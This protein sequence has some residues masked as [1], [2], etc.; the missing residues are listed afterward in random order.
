ME[1]FFL[2]SI[3][4]DVSK[5]K[6]MVAVLRPL[7]EVV[8]VPFEVN[9]TVKELTALIKD[10]KSL[11]GD[12]KVFME[13][14]G[15]YHLPIANALT[16]AGFKVHTLNAMLIKN[17][18]NNSI[19]KVKTDKADALKIANY[20]LTYWND[21]TVYSIDD[22]IRIKLKSFN[23]QYSKYIK[24]RTAM[25]NNFTSLID[26]SFPGV[27]TLFSSP[28]RKS[29]GHKK[30][31]DFSLRYWHCDCVAAMSLN[32]FISSYQAWCKVHKY[33][34]SHSKAEEIHQF[35]R[36]CCPV[37]PKDEETK[38]LIC[39]A[40][41]ELNTLT[42]ATNSI[43]VKALELAS[44]LPE[45]PVV[46]KMYGVGDITAF[47]LIAEIGNIYRFPRKTSLVS[48]AGLDTEPNDSGI[49][50]HNSNEITKKGSPYLRRTLFLVMSNI[51]MLAPS[52]EP[53][54]QFLDRKRSEGKHYYTYLCAGAAKFLR[55]YYARVKEYL[56]K[57]S[58]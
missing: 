42:E 47:Q 48:Y 16:S 23:R 3:G 40:A 27:N 5:G 32:A 25:S 33:N 29:D 37:I 11:S 12:S 31:I 4:I 52:D 21:V 6:S 35:A 45:Y 20:G 30:W 26:L 56:D 8:R 28:E 55:I 14:T 51:L 17:F 24:L 46:A 22:D 39:T 7:G 34:Y 18:G 1:V 36:Q 2:N 57:Q 19:R 41:K 10:L 15:S 58:S 44:Q 9:H 50:K 54:Y 43:A 49:V 53:I 13:C 38:F